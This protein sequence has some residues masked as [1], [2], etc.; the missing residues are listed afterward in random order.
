MRSSMSLNGY[1]QSHM[2]LTYMGSDMDIKHERDYLKK[3]LEKR[4]LK[5]YNDD[6]K[7]NK[8]PLSTGAI[9]GIVIAIVV[10]IAAVVVGVLIFLKRRNNEASEF[11]LSK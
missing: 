2:T 6:G 7:T 11:M 4:A 1:K 3:Y 9:I 8:K 5:S 10:V